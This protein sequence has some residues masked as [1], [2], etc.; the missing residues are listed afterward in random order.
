[1]RGLG[2]TPDFLVGQDQCPKVYPHSSWPLLLGEEELDALLSF[3]DQRFGIPREVTLGLTWY[4]RADHVHVLS[5][6]DHLKRAV[7]YKVAN[8]GIRVFGVHKKEGR[9]LFMPNK[10]FL[11]VFKGFIRKGI[12]YLTEKE[13]QEIKGRY[14]LKEL[15]LA[16]GPVV[17]GLEGFDLIGIGFYK[18]GLLRA[19][20]L[21][22]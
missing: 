2:D 9:I 16:P 8:V 22:I 17:L 4:L 5:T 6:S 14:L 11:S 7:R 10:W 19:Q 12:V 18:E 3:L 21:W 13:L 1:M 15:D 20:G